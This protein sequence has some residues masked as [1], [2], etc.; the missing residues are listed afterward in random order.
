MFSSKQIH[1][2][3]FHWA[4]PLTYMC[5]EFVFKMASAI[6]LFSLLSLLS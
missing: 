4:H 3:P 2:V 5:N 6:T 1:N